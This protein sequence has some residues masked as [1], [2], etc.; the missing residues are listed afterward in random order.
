[1]ILKKSRNPA[2]VAHK[3][4][5]LNSLQEYIEAHAR[6]DTTHDT[7]TA[8]IWT[9]PMGL[10][11]GEVFLRL[12]CICWR[13]RLRLRPSVLEVA[14]ATPRTTSKQLNLL[15]TAYATL[16]DIRWIGHTVACLDAQQ[17]DTKTH[18]SSVKPTTD[19]FHATSGGALFIHSFGSPARRSCEGIRCNG[20]I[21]DLQ[22]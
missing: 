4:H 17:L 20:E 16:S 5:L 13:L 21:Q 1:M 7:K 8:S 19:R 6:A 18:E 15:A 12:G 22:Q 3:C 10:D 11:L 14:N 2:Q 9:V